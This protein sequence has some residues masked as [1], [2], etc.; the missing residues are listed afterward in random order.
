MKRLVVNADDLGADEGRNRGILEAVEK[1]SVTSVSILVNGPAL[2]DALA[3]IRGL[4]ETRVSCGIHLN[5]SEG[6]PLSGGLRLLTGPDGRF[7][8]KEAAHRLLMRQGDADLEREVGKE[9]HEQIRRVRETG[10]S[11]RHLN[12]HQHVHVFPA[13]VRTAMRAAADH[14][15]PWIRIPDERLPRGANGVDCADLDE[16]IRLFSGLAG[17]ARGLLEAWS[18]R[19]PDRFFGLSCK[20]RLTRESLGAM[21]RCMPAGLA[22]LM[23]HPGRMPSRRSEGPFRSFSTPER[24]QELEALLAPFF[25]EILAREGIELTP[26]PP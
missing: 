16:E 25:R 12:G 1:G 2:E 8:G 6:E 26:F 23:V 20:G 11:V 24:Q 15:I 18:L 14:G 9:V 5:L 21:A 7:L 4:G 10:V 3:Q 22:E 17:E 19:A 13:V